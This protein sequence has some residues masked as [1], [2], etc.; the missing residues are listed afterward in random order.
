MLFYCVAY[1]SSK[2]QTLQSEHIYKTNNSFKIRGDTY[3]DKTL[4]K[5]YKQKK[6]ERE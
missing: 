5:V 6:Q 1:N 3:I 4:N 2:T